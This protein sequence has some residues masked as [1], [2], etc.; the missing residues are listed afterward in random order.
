MVR[1][2]AVAARNS[3]PIDVSRFVSKNLLSSHVE[4]SL[5]IDILGDNTLR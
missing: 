3:C 1:K 4:T 2:V 5:L